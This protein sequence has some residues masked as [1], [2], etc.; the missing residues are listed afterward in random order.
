MPDWN[1]QHWID[2]AESGNQQRLR[3]RDGKLWQGW[4]MELNDGALL[5]SVGE[6]ERGQG[7]WLALDQIDRESLAFFDPRGAGW[8]AF[9][10]DPDS[11][12]D[13]DHIG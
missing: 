1:E 4:I 9:R 3:T 11:Y 7:Q 8:T 13:I 10:F 12:P 2:F 5:I 6:G